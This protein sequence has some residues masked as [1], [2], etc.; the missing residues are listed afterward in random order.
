MSLL[1][2]DEL[3]DSL[4]NKGYYIFDL[5]KKS[6]D[7]INKIFDQKLVPDINRFD[8]ETGIHPE[9]TKYLIKN[10]HL[11]SPLFRDLIFDNNIRSSLS[12][13]ET[14][15][16]YKFHIIR[17]SL[18]L[19]K[20]GR[21]HNWHTDAH[22]CQNIKNSQEL[23]MQIGLSDANLEN[24]IE[25]T[26]G[27]HKWK[28]DPWSEEWKNEKRKYFQNSNKVKVPLKKGQ[29]LIF[30]GN[31]LHRTFSIENFTGTRYGIAVRYVNGKDGL[32]YNDNVFGESL[33]LQHFPITYEKVKNISKIKLNIPNCQSIKF[34][35]LKNSVVVISGASGRWGEIGKTLAIAYAQQG[36]NLALSAR[37]DLTDFSLQLQE[38]YKVNVIIGKVDITN[39][40]TC[41]KFANIVKEIYGHVDIII[42]NA[43]LSCGGSLC[44][45]D[46][47]PK[48]F[49][50]SLKINLI[51]PYN[52]TSSFIPLIKKD[53][54]LGSILFIGSGSGILPWGENKN[55]GY[56]IGKAG[57]HYMSRLYAMEFEKMNHKINVN[58]ILPGLTN[59]TGEGGKE[60]G[61]YFDP[62]KTANY[63]VPLALLVTS[64]KKG[65]GPSGQTFAWHR[66]PIF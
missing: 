5:E 14:K 17:S 9:G 31:V 47:N 49:N 38:T 63:L 16:N 12:K 26:E 15:K 11:D 19:K 34:E 58:E 50:K 1:N 56:T 46:S 23:S 27:S 21:S 37:S 10:R 28:G 55:A 39:L 30:W 64:H 54:E 24:C 13:I 61:L 51:G 3:Y 29:C 42:N 48:T 43:A 18:M 44:E 22:L 40:D 53:R 57:V 35:S 32:K 41:N 6:L 66:R 33:P 59:K 45:E 36:A 60:F 2:Y 4:E 25:L 20:K 65:V 62:A 52:F 8:H 7:I